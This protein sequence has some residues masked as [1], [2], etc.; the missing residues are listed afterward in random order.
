M[1]S[2]TLRTWTSVATT[3]RLVAM[4]TTTL[5]L[6]ERMRLAAGVPIG[7]PD[8]ISDLD[9]VRRVVRAP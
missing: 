6:T 5:V 3:S 9:R 4:G 1:R 2:V 8:K 7:T